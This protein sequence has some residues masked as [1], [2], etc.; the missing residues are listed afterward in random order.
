M[1][2]PATHLR[3]ALELMPPALASQS[4]K[5]AYLAG[6]LYPDSRMLTGISREQTHADA[7]LADGF[8]TNPFRLGWQMH[9]GCDLIQARVHARLWPAAARLSEP[10]RWIS[11]S[12]AKMV[13]DDVDRTAV[14]LLE[15][16]ATLTPAETPFGEESAAIGR[17]YDLIYAVYAAAGIS[18]RERFAR[19]WAGVGLEKALIAELIA[20][21]EALRADA[22]LAGRIGG[23]M[24]ALLDHAVTPATLPH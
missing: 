17:F 21:Y 10:R 14:P 12:A 23:S 7:C 11:M 1:A 24:T 4:E 5:T 15:H 3:Y 19:L 13:Q 22:P 8:A 2:L 20:A 6:T 9:C 18:S 16:L